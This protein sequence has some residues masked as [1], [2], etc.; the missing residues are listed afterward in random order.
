MR[1]RAGIPPVTPERQ[2]AQ[3]NMSDS[4][5]GTERASNIPIQGGGGPTTNG[6]DT[7]A[8]AAGSPASAAANMLIEGI[9]INSLALIRHPQQGGFAWCRVAGLNVAHT[10]GKM[11]VVQ[12]VPRFR[13]V[14]GLPV[15]IVFIDR[16]DCFSCDRSDLIVPVM[17]GPVS[18]TACLDLDDM[19]TYVCT[20]GHVRP[21][22]VPNA[23]AL[24]LDASDEFIM[25]YMKKRSS[26]VSHK[27]I[28]EDIENEDF[29]ELLAPA[30]F[31]VSESGTAPMSIHD[32]LNQFQGE[33][34]YLALPDEY[35][36]TGEEQWSP[37][38]RTHSGRRVCQT[39]KYDGAAG[40]AASK[41][42]SDRSERAA[43][44][45]GDKKRKQVQ[46]HEENDAAVDKAFWDA[47][48]NSH[49]KKPCT[50]TIAIVE[51]YDQRQ[52]DV[53]RKEEERRSN[54]FRRGE[55]A[56]SN[57]VEEANTQEPPALS[58]FP[59]VASVRRSE[60]K[61]AKKR[62][63]RNRLLKVW[64]M[65]AATMDGDRYR[66]A[67][68]LQLP[69]TGPETIA[70]EKAGVSV[71]YEIVDRPIDLYTIKARIENNE[72]AD[73]K[74]MQADMMLLFNN[75]RKFDS[76]INEPDDRWVTEDADALQESMVKAL[77]SECGMRQSGAAMN[78]SRA[79]R[80][81]KARA[82]AGGA[83]SKQA[84]GK[85]AVVR[86]SKHPVT[87]KPTNATGGKPAANAA[88]MVSQI[89]APP[90]SKT[91]QSAVV[92]A[93]PK[94]THND[95]KEPAAGNKQGRRWSEA[96]PSSVTHLNRPNDPMVIH[97]PP[98]HFI[99]AKRSVTLSHMWWPVEDLPSRNQC[100]I[101]KL[102]AKKIGNWDR[103]PA[104]FREIVGDTDNVA[105]SCTDKGQIVQYMCIQ[106]I[107]ATDHGAS[108]PAYLITDVHE[109]TTGYADVH[110]ESLLANILAR[111]ACGKLEHSRFVKYADASMNIQP[112]IRNGFTLHS[113]FDSERCD[114]PPGCRGLLVR[115]VQPARDQGGPFSALGAFETLKRRNDELSRK[116]DELKNAQEKMREATAAKDK[117]V[118]EVTATAPVLADLRAANGG[119]REKLREATAAK[120][121][122]VKEVTATASTLAEIRARCSKKD[123]ENETMRAEIATLQ[124]KLR[125][126]TIRDFPVDATENERLKKDI[127][128]LDAK[129]ELLKKDIARLGRDYRGE[130]E[131]RENLEGDMSRLDRDYHSLAAFLFNDD[132]PC[133]IRLRCPTRKPSATE[134]DRPR[135]AEYKWDEKYQQ[136]VE[137]DARCWFPPK[138]IDVVR[139]TEARQGQVFRF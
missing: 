17:W 25:S 81:S 28:I 136:W 18:A 139:Y 74:A 10:G 47:K 41:W 116:N 135:G 34:F 1:G 66:A 13:R 67:L 91:Q 49:T 55:E 111:S 110:I 90:A 134:R 30:T 51:A 107:T 108:V 16:S 92:T 6:N 86:A 44:I 9:K 98:D 100:E 94:P 5:G 83:L 48:S 60:K 42:S 26:S 70:D 15:G 40:V 112:Y 133:R 59:I 4:D 77:D 99:P 126:V 96:R 11:M 127:A 137:D 82:V 63:M 97:L 124:G 12:V 120:D 68:F 129:N 130:K 62:A 2:R 72:Y 80:G 75:A 125:E 32:V 132:T 53:Q 24:T 3:G 84:A 29:G 50:E 46:L 131:R 89:Q 57:S 87:S 71:Y 106:E 101:A 73:H 36:V 33:K 119:L 121:K 85:A 138:R 76:S 19:S 8:A 118:K 39:E 128:H 7:A 45:A 69:G 79:S 52:A 54:A 22:T 27:S 113:H 78:T 56:V 43:K 115:K 37:P 122:A 95:T 20:D 105:Y 103:E 117:A 58:P 31:A 61:V 65:V 109:D 23:K 93:P 102:H 114:I 38:A 123:G 104:P 88:T 14:C 35:D 21:W 64:Q